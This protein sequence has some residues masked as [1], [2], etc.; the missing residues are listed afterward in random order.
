MLA[1]V[2]A[3]LVAVGLWQLTGLFLQ[4]IFVS[5]PSAVIPALFHLIV[6]GPLPTA[7]LSSLLEMVI[8]IIA[9]AMVGV[10]LAC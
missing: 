9:A 6:G 2:L 4:P 3:V 8:G 5:T 7:F 10:G 1:G